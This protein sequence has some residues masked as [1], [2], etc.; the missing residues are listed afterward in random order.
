ML[1]VERNIS[2]TV[3]TFKPASP[4]EY[5]GMY[6]LIT[7]NNHR[8]EPGL[9][10]TGVN[11]YAGKSCRNL[12][13]TYNNLVIDGLQPNLALCD[14]NTFG[15]I[16]RG[17]TEYFRTDPIQTFTQGISKISLGVPE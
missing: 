13:E 8:T 10:G 17:L 9:N 6:E 14:Y 4:L 5:Q 2:Q 11:T 16:R 3:N 15:V 7:T 1:G 12:D